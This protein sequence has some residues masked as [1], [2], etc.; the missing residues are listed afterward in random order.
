[1]KFFT[2]AS[3]ANLLALSTAIN[4]NNFSV[5]NLDELNI[6]EIVDKINQ[7]ND[8]SW[9]AATNF[10]EPN[11]LPSKYQYL[12]GTFLGDHPDGYTLPTKT[13]DKKLLQEYDLPANFD[14][15]EKWPECSHSLKLIRDQGSCGS[16]WAFGAAEAM[17]DRVC[18]ASKGNFHGDISS[19]DI[20]ACCG[21]TCGSGCNGGWPLMAWRYFKKHGVVTGGLYG[22][23]QSGCLP[24]VI[25]PCQH[26]TVG[27][28]PPCEGEEG[29]TPKCPHKCIPESGLTWKDDKHYAVS[30]YKLPNDEKAI[31]KELYE[32]GPAEAALTVYE[33]FMAYKGGVYHHVHGKALGGHAIRLVGW[34]ESMEGGVHEKYWLLAN[35]WN[36]DWGENGYFRIRRGTNEC[37][38]EEEVVAGI[39]KAVNNKDKFPSFFQIDDKEDSNEIL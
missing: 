37:G 9:S 17:S 15:S 14:P 36:S 34:G 2:L 1:M 28:R 10:M 24:Y 6:Q 19:E 13:T 18:I 29:H 27:P 7:N 38:I 11:D 39:A 4:N 31:M 3:A 25:E 32:N 21:F 5:D 20:L 26:H 23:L 33:D 30:A 35:S 8:I 22:D 16:C 12:M